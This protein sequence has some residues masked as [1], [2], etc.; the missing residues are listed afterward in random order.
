MDT[1]NFAIGVLSITAAILLT[2]LFLVQAFGPQQALAFGQSAASGDYVV[3]TSQLDGN[4]ELLVILD[5]AIP[6]MNIY[7]F[8]T[9]RN[10]IELIQQVDLRPLT[11]Q[12]LRQFRGRRAPGQPEGQPTAPQRGER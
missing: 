1:R 2:G 8:N 11:R 7:G 12:A 9:Q 10:L 4:A 3:S 6:G 5:T